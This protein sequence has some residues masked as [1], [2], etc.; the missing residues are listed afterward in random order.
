MAQ[1]KNLGRVTVVPRGA[2]SAGA[3]YE[4]LDV[5]SYG[6]SSWMALQNVTGVTPSAGQYWMQIAAKGS[7]GSNGQS[8]TVAIGT[9][10]S[11]PYGTPSSVTNVGTA[12]NAV[13]NMSLQTGP[14]GADGD[15][16]VLTSQDK[17]DIAALVDDMFVVTVS[18]TDPVIVGAANTRYI[19]GTVNTI[20]IT[21]PVSGI[22]DVI[23]T[24]GATLAVVTLPN[25]VRM[26]DWYSIE[27]N[28]TYEINIQ[29]GVYGAV[30]SWAG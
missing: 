18:G 15:D 23:F 21:P 20:S 19:C 8:C 16:Y 11:V 24:S 30:M 7:D 3:E 22:I 29:D 2:Y 25:T 4:R 14:Q 26:P 12:N 13:F 6:G 10:T 1:T 27:T 28:R 5:V 17:N 9:V